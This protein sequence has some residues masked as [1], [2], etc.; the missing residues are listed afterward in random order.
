MY[1]IR[2]GALRPDPRIVLRQAPATG[3]DV[4]ALQKKLARMDK[5]GAWT[6]QVLNI[7]AEHP[8]VRAGDLCVLIGQDKDDFKRNVRK[9]KNLG[10]TE[11]L[12]RGYR[13]WPRGRG[14]LGQILP[15][16]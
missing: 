10:L 16:E 1:R 6:A 3:A 8:E 2:L 4:A 7:S 13:L 11:S 15:F 9:L 14:L 5:A 12:E